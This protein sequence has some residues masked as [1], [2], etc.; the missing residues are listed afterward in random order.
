[1]AERANRLEH[2]IKAGPSKLQSAFAA[3]YQKGVNGKLLITE[4]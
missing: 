3:R 4:E 2:R 1:M